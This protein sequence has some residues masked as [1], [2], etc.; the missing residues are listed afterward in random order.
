MVRFGS[1]SLRVLTYHRIANANDFPWLDPRLISATP[2][3]FE[4]QMRYLA[5]HYDVVDAERVLNAANGGQTLPRRP[6]LITFDD[7]Y[8]DFA[9]YAWP[10]LQ[11]Y[12]LPVTLFVP[13][14]FAG[15]PHTLFWWDRLYHAVVPAGADCEELARLK[16][17]QRWL[18]TIPHSEAMQFV[19]ALCR[20]HGAA[21]PA[22]PSALDWD[23]LRK[24]AREG[25][26]IASHTRTHPILTKIPLAEAKEEIQASIADV[27]HYLG[28]M[29]PVFCYPNGSVDD[30]VA[31]SLKAEGIQ[32][33]FT[34]QPGHNDVPAPDPLRL[35]RINITPR[36]TLAVFRIRLMRAG[37][38]IDRWRAAA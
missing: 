18:T 8:A 33:A 28:E 2:E 37:N 36:T 25:V 13:T 20:Q 6:V 15:N 7:G 34:T 26:C 4:R 31:H 11:R 23:Q 24:L 27:R 29:L 12:N 38:V 17:L 19:D 21:R 22:R 3:T 1:L 35:H 30:D 5:G 10:I 9:R 32:M 14:A 16:R